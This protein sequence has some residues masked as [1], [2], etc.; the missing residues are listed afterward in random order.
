VSE[1]LRRGF[2]GGNVATICV[3]DGGRRGEAVVLGFPQAVES[4]E[5]REERWDLLREAQWSLRQWEL[6]RRDV[7]RARLVASLD[8]LSALVRSTG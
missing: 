3:S 8:L 5:A 7:D 1:S 6:H 2:P 4:V